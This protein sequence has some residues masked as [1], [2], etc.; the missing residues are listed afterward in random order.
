MVKS[1]YIRYKEA[2]YNDDL[3]DFV[4]EL[5]DEELTQLWNA[6]GNEEIGEE[7]DIRKGKI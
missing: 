7:I 1:I 5:D 4:E 6:T 2:F 3:Q